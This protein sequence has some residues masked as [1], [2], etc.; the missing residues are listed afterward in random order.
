[1][2]MVQVPEPTVFLDNADQRAVYALQEFHSLFQGEL[3]I[4]D[5]FSRL[6]HLADLLRDVRHPVSDLAMVINALCGLNFK[7]SHAIS[8]LTARKPL[9][10]TRRFLAAQGHQK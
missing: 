10:E 5:Y 6:K 2:Q 7:F 9:Q 4:H 1:M 8:V 3:P